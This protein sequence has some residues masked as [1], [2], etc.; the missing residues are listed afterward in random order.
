MHASACLHALI[1]QVTKWLGRCHWPH[2]IRMLL[3]IRFSLN[4]VVI[5]K[6]GHCV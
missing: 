2:G 4:Q 6:L 1:T 5:R 3:H